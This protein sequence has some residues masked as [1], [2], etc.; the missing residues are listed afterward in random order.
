MSWASE[1]PPWKNV[2]WYSSSTTVLDTS[3]PAIETSLLLPLPDLDG[4]I[5]GLK[6]TIESLDRLNEWEYLK[7]TSNPY[8][9]VFSQ[10]HDIRIP[11]SVSSLRPL[12]RSF[13]KMVEILT[14]LNFYKRHTSATISSA[15]VC[16]G[17][18]GFIEA[19]LY[20][21]LKKSK[22]VTKSWAMT[23]KPTMPNIPGWKRA[24][25]FLRKSPMIH[26]EYGADHTGNIMVLANQHEFLSKS[27]LLD[28]LLC[29]MGSDL[30]EV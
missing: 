8:E 25:H 24:Y 5:V 13:F 9:L 16:E 3:I 10:S 30:R 1:T 12:S 17:P 23:L 4:S 11:A 26:I 7:K 18:G 22:T 21:A 28:F 6:H 14:V 2:K 27:M 29:V 19:L 20:M 15:H